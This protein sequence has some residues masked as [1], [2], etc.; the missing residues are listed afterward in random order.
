MEHYVQIENIDGVDTMKECWDTPPECGVG[1]EGWKNAIEIKP[2][3]DPRRQ[4]YTNHVFDLTVDPVQIKWGC[5][6]HPVQSRVEELTE[7]SEFPMFVL[8]NNMAR[9]IIPYDHELIMSTQATAD[10]LRACLQVATTHNQLDAIEDGIA[11]TPEEVLA[12]TEPDAIL[13]EIVV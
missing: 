9:K 11:K 7:M 1:N 12:I 3:I 8:F 6:N 5:K 10:Q 4:R 13:E 2:E